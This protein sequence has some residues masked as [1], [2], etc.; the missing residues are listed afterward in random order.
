MSFLIGFVSA[1]LLYGGQANRFQREAADWKKNTTTST[2]KWQH[3]REKH[4]L[5][6]G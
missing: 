2:S 5:S 1:W 6:L 4:D 3:P